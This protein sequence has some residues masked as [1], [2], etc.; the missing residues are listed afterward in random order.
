MTPERLLTVGACVVA[1]L[2]AS[3]AIANADG[4]DLPNKAL[5][6]GVA[7]PN[8]TAADV[9]SPGYAGRVRLVTEATKRKVYASYHLQ[10]DGKRYEV[11][12]LISLELG[13]SNDP[14]NLWPQHYSEPNGAH[15]K[16]KLEDELHRLVCSGKMTLTEAQKAIVGD[17]IAA[18]KKRGL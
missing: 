14:R 6:P 16:D 8:V 5:T 13:G 10:P 4:P 1:L 11:D 7:L 2:L 18:K 17:W 12:H 3:L 15:D 9:C